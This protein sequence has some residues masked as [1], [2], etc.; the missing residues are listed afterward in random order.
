MNIYLIGFMGTGKT[1][2]GKV[3]S[4]MMNTRLLDTDELIVEQEKRSIP[5]IFREEGEAGFRNIEKGI[6][7]KLSKD[8]SDYVISCGGGAPLSSENVS[9]MKKNGVVVRLLASPQT[10]YDRVKDDDGR[11]LLSS[12]DAL[13]GII[14]LMKDRERAYREAA[15][16]AIDT[17]GR[18]P[19]EVAAEIVES[20]TKKG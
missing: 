14:S 10:V 15:D 12:E 20:L 9:C 17:D 4:E 16:I 6:F 8:T 5:D 18:T 11:P 1:S 13:S 19:D 7:R 2:T 3:L